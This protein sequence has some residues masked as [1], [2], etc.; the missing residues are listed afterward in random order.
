MDCPVTM[1]L[2][3]YVLGGADAR[4]RL[5]LADHVPGCPACREELA[6]L[7]AI[8]GL[9]ARLPPAMIPGDVPPPSPA[10]VSAAPGRLTRLVPSRA[11]RATALTA[12]ALAVGLG[13][14]FS[15]AV[16]AASP[17]ATPGAGVAAGHGVTFSGDNPATHVRAT[18]VLTATS[19]GTRIELRLSGA[20]RN[21]QCSL[22]VVTRAGVREQAGIWSAWR[23][24]PIKVPASASWHLYDISRLTITS[25]ARRLATLTAHRAGPAR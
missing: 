18:A 20:P 11:W 13:A 9:L 6:G 5:L 15:L 21:Q 19:W 16:P 17:P 3:A 10:A 8:P 22:I 4:E 1:S 7:A 23:G 2:S 24:G 25:G 12:V 14:G